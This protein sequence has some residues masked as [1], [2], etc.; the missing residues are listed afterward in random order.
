MD[1]ITISLLAATLMFGVQGARADHETETKARNSHKSANEI[2][3]TKVTNAQNED[4]G[5][6]LDL[7]V[8]I[9]AGTSPYAII[10]TGGVLG[11]NRSRIAVPLSSLRC[12]A[13]GK[14]LVLSATKEEL[15]AAS[16]S[17]TGAWA[18]VANSQWA[19]RVDGFYGQP[20]Q[21]D[22]FARDTVREDDAR[23]Y[24]RDPLPKGGE[25]LITPQDAALCESICEKVEAVHVRVQNGVTHIYGQVENEEDRKNLE[26]KVRAVPGVNA[27]ESHVK[28][29][30][31]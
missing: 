14:E 21:R 22:R 31:P 8:N 6:V 15:R 19:R 1:R 20:K 9:D 12:S 17:A 7:I 24:V 13:D 11:V 4:V 23:T 30:N 29:K 2:I 5:K 26:A 28:I 10:S 25:L 18:P 3:G 27:V 16:K